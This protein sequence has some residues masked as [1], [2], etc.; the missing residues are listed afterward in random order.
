M[1]TRF[2]PVAALV[3][4]GI[5]AGTLSACGGGD[6]NSGGGSYAVGGTVSGLAGS[7][8]VLRDNGG[9]DLPVSASGPFAFDTMVAS[10]KSYAVTVYTQPTNPDQ[11]CV[12]TNGSGMVGSSNV[13]NVAVACATA[14]TIGGTVSGL[15]GSGLMLN[16]KSGSGSIGVSAN[17]SFTLPGSFSSGDAYAVT[18]ATQP[19]NPV[20]NCTV[21]NGTGSGTVADANVTSV[22]VV[23]ADVGRFAYV[24]NEG[25]DTISA[26]TIDPVTG[27][28]TPVAGSPFAAKRAHALAVDPAGHFLYAAN[29]DSTGVS[30]WAIDA[31]TGAL[32]EVTGS[33]FAAD[34]AP[35]GVTVDP[36]GRFVYVA[37]VNSFDVSGFTVDSSAGVLTPIAGSPFT[38]G[39]NPSSVTVDPTGK[40][41]YVTNMNGSAD[42][43]SAYT[44]DPT[45][46]ALTPLTSPMTSTG[47]QPY[48]IVVDPNGKYAY[49]GND[50]SGNISAYS[51][52]AATGAL[53]AVLGSPYAI[54][55]PGA[56]SV[57]IDP[58]GTFV[59]AVSTAGGNSSGGNSVTAFTVNAATGALTPVPGSPFATGQGP[60][61]VATDPSG[62]FAF[63]ASEQTADVTVYLIDATT[64]ALGPVAG[65]PFA[66]G[67]DAASVVIA[68]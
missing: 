40:F 48:G 57:T 2:S 5:T 62:K 50:G 41:A 59:Y 60:F 16:T 26:Y 30:V 23:C 45:T 34:V 68:K 67:H 21:T 28:L 61:S 24:A 22:A 9:D 20:Q 36:S 65:S 15:K 12:V 33:P 17:G 64:G 49:V 66:A 7:G 10:G 32:T 1:N 35:L 18:V 43:I 63:V 46:G 37:N 55:G 6:G 4:A 54:D 13:T 3:L 25:D 51:L 38:A 58:S 39:Y 11:T 44:I 56:T 19:T 53:T 27:A 14:H 31:N 29:F 42:N 52:D 47:D 8:L